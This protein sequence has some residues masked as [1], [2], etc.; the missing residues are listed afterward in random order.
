[1]TQYNANGS[2]GKIEDNIT[3]MRKA[4]KEF[5]D[6]LSIMSNLSHALLFVDKD[7]Y[8]DECIELC[9]KVLGKS[10]DDS[11]RFV[12][13]QTL[14]YS[15]NKKKNVKKA[16]EYA[17]KLPDL[18][19]T[20]SIV[21]EGVLD[22]QERLKLTQANIVTLVGLLDNSITWMLRSKV[23]TSEEKIFV[24]ETLDTLYKLFFYDGNY[25]YEHS[26]L[27]MLWM[28]L[29]REYAKCENKERTINALKTAYLHAYEMDHFKPGKYTSIFADTGSYSVEGFT[30]NFE[31]SYID[32][33]KKTMEDKV[34]DFIRKTD[35]F[36]HI[37]V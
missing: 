37:I 11:Q 25:G 17:E 18:C 20:K 22:G 4:L 10:V 24:Y 35:E 30:K 12:T 14:I 23:Y 27:L 19:C 31:T 8:L 16:K 21:L 13:L 26:A 1:M 36:Q 34:F 29:S 32:W 3:L 28:N 9:E 6:N 15:Y 2:A 5:P 33:L 7:E